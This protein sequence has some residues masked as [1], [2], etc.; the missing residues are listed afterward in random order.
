[1]PEDK[2]PE[3]APHRDLTEETKRE[4]EKIEDDVLSEPTA[5]EKRALRFR[6][7][8]RAAKETV[9]TLAG[10]CMDMAS[11]L[12]EKSKAI[13]SND[14]LADFKA[15]HKFNESARQFK[16]A[17]AITDRSHMRYV[18]AIHLEEE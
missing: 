11:A 9:D 7:R 4:Q 13:E 5:E 16:A 15:A 10:H 17:L 3:N 8:E 2:P 18:D 12:R 14:L 1:M 6:L